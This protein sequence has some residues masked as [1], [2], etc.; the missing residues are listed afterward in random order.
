MLEDDILRV[1]HSD[2]PTPVKDLA[3]LLRINGRAGLRKAEVSVILKKLKSEKKVFR[4]SDGRWQPSLSSTL[5]P[6]TLEEKRNGSP[7]T[8]SHR[9]SET[10]KSFEFEKTVEDDEITSVEDLDLDPRQKSFKGSLAQLRQRLLDLRNRNKLLNFRFSN[11]SRNHSRVIDELP[12]HLFQKLL[13]GGKLLIRSL[14][15]PEIDPAD[16]KSETFLRA[17]TIAR[18]E[19]DTPQ[20]NLPQV[21]DPETT[22]SKDRK[23]ERKLKDKVRSQLGMKPRPNK[24][25]LSIEEYAREHRLNPS[26]ELPHPSGN[27]NDL[28]K[29]TD[30][31]IQTLLYPEQM[32]SKFSGIRDGARTAQQEMGINIL[33]VAFGFLEWQESESSDKSL[34]A[35]LLLVPIQMERTLKKGSYRFEA[36]ST[37]E[38]P[39]INITLRERFRQDFGLEIPDIDSNEQPEDYFEKVRHVIKNKKRWKIRRFV[40]IG[41]FDFARLAMY[42][43][44]DPSKWPTSGNILLHSGLGTL[45]GGGAKETQL[46]GEVY[47]VDTPQ[48]RAKVPLTVKDADSSQFSAIVDVMNG[49]DLALKGPPGTGKSQTITNMI[50]A[51]LHDGKRILFLAEKMA[52]LEVVKSRLD[53][54][55]LGDFCLEL[56]STKSRKK[57]V[58]KSI[59]ERRELS[60]R[61]RPHMLDAEIKREERLREQLSRYCKIINTSIGAASKSIHDAIWGATRFRELAKNSEVGVNLDTVE[62]LNS[63]LLDSNGIEDCVANLQ[64]LRDKAK[65]AGISGQNHTEHPFWGIH[66]SNLTPFEIRALL[67]QFAQWKLQITALFDQSKKSAITTKLDEPSSL[68]EIINLANAL[69]SIPE[70]KYSESPNLLPFLRDGL[71]DSKLSATL[72]AVNAAISAD[73]ALRDARN[74][75]EDLNLS[76]IQTIE[77]RL[78]DLQSSPVG[79][80]ISKQTADLKSGPDIVENIIRN[81]NQAQELLKGFNQSLE[82]FIGCSIETGID[83]Q[84]ALNAAELIRKTPGDVISRRSKDLTDE[85]VHSYLSKKQKEFLELQKRRE[86]LSTQ[87]HFKTLG[88]GN[89]SSRDVR[90]HLRTLRETG[91][92]GRF[93]SA[94]YKTTWALCLELSISKP[95]PHRTEFE[96]TLKTLADY[97]EDQEMSTNDPRIQELCSI[98]FEGI[99]TV[100]NPFCGVFE[101]SNQTTKDIIGKKKLSTGLRRAILESSVED[102]QLF[103]NSIPEAD[104]A[105]W[106]SLSS[107]LIQSGVT[108]SAEDNLQQI[109]EE[110]QVTSSKLCKIYSD[111]L[112]AG[113][114]EN[115]QLDQMPRLST[116]ACSLEQSQS[117]LERS[118]L[119]KLIGCDPKDFAK[120]SPILEDA[121]RVGELIDSLDLSADEKKRLKSNDLNDI[122]REL[123]TTLADL[124]LET[125]KESTAREKLTELGDI[126]WE[127]FLDNGLLASPQALINTRVNCLTENKDNLPTWSELNGAFQKSKEMGLDSLTTA[128][129]DGREEFSSIDT[130]FRYVY[131]R[132]LLEHAYKQYPEL[133][134]FSGAELSQMRERYRESDKKLNELQSQDL[135]Y[136]LAQNDLNVGN[137]DG[138]RGT[139]TG[140]N[141]IHNEINKKRRHIPIRA[142]IARAGETIQNLKPCW[143]MSPASVAQFLKPNGVKFDIVIIDEASQ[144]RP[145]EALGAIARSDQ[146]VVVGDPQQLPPTSFFERLGVDEEVDDEDVIDTESILNKALESFHPFRELQWHYRSRHES[147]IAFSNHQFYGGKLIVF[148][149]PKPVHIDLGVEYVYIENGRYI[150]GASINPTEAET[151]VNAALEFMTLH[152]KRSLGIV[153]MNMKQ[154]ELVLQ[155][156]E[157]R[158]TK[159]KKAADYVSYW[160]ETLFSFFVKN[161]ENV[162]GDERDVIMIST[163]YGPDESGKTRQRFGPINSLDGHRRLNV[164]FTRAREKVIVFS[165]MQPSDIL[166]SDGARRGVKI[167]KDYLEYAFTGQIHKG[168]VTDRPPD[169]DFEI[170][171]ADELKRAGYEVQPQVGVAGFFLD[172]AVKDPHNGSQYICAVEC[173]GATY[174]SAKSARD[175]DRLR[176][177]ILEGLGWKVLR[178]WSTDWFNDPAKETRKLIKKIRSL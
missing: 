136:H 69:K 140:L 57:D 84:D 96:E 36:S 118:E 17:L 165:S 169:S 12:N 167:F 55:G 151:V 94:Q 129:L 126:H 68:E 111:L 142:L 49:K 164:L 45:F 154:R 77:G 89:V 75:A 109:L 106:N 24:E 26:Y 166:A 34:F 168:E 139:W 147:L 128:Y 23:S 42:F 79:L 11:R 105:A 53:D 93:F 72:S 149:T 58:L 98:D 153:T 22:S 38:E 71:Q 28:K 124:N 175:R 29:H 83:T 21:D 2:G 135:Q 99:D 108:I 132:S 88:R 91:F 120:I 119:P 146:V 16:E 110:V 52:A 73:E 178:V 156:M 43:D 30:N 47:D 143:L 48:I 160:D 122:N 114:S 50:A 8:N 162:Q 51:A 64:V 103:S 134:E 112:Q 74:R 101:L 130:S 78:K 95:S 14:P 59:N 9:T 35:P 46:T 40:A 86:S 145:E 80:S 54:V 177:E 37:G 31:E 82:S 144:M 56:H 131:Y 174:H 137:G 115:V 87:I 161:L 123:A 176:Q 61:S 90:N 10:R 159:D 155:E 116:L 3:S 66:C 7:R 113:L 25:E 76:E 127:E 125:Q 150:T 20:L 18:L 85:R 138:P 107:S 6:K 81:A 172:I 117:I 173:D 171:V 33:F 39:K 44:L 13:E 67:E 19:D 152:P 100:L 157:R 170:H 141:L 27:E 4:D 104:I 41:L 60:I 97:L 65:E 163:V 5:S 1:L 63:V 92:L 121:I 102:L 70:P 15:D 133:R 32:E 62:F 148:P 158:I